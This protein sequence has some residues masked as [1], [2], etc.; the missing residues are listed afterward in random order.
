[1]HEKLSELRVVLES[2]IRGMSP[3]E[4]VR[5]REGKWSALQIL[6]HLNLTYN[7]T[8]KNFE[9]CLATGKSCASPDRSQKRWQRIVVTGIG[10]FPPGRTSPARVEPRANPPE[11]LTSEVLKN[12]ER[13]DSLIAEIDSRFGHGEPLADHPIL[14]PLTAAEWRKFHLVHGKHHAKQIIRLCKR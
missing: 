5:P 4:L 8:I 10:I 11:E 12:I 7:G 14:G 1:M 9:R 2:A 6:D 3:E 13:M